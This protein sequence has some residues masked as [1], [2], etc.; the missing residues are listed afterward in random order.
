[1]LLSITLFLPL[2]G[3]LAIMLGARG[4]GADGKAKGLAL[5][6]SVATF[7]VSLL[8]L[9]GFDAS[10]PEI[11]LAERYEWIAGWGYAFSKKDNSRSSI[12]LRSWHSSPLR[13]R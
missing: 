12:V 9:N 2:I 10:N 8:I 6:F 5:A 11:Q 13:Q 3:A 7:L 4:E 1:M